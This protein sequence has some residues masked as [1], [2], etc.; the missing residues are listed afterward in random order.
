MQES[1]EKDRWLSENVVCPLYSPEGAWL[2]VNASPQ[3][4]LDFRCSGD[5]AGRGFRPDKIA[6]LPYVECVG[7]RPERSACNGPSGS[8]HISKLLR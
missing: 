4:A 6:Q 7:H 1:G 3:G 2:E 5:R 8:A